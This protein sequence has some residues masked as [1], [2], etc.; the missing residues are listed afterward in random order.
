MSLPPPDYHTTRTIG[1]GQSNPADVRRLRRALTRAGYGRFGNPPAENVTPGLMT[2]IARFQS[3]FGLEPDSV[4]RP[5][6]PTERALTMALRARSD[7]GDPALAEL[8]ETFA[9]NTAAGLT[10]RPHPRDRNAGLWLDGSSGS[11]GTS[12]RQPNE[13]QVA[14]GP[15]ALLM[16]GGRA[17]L[18]YLGRA[19]GLGTGAA[20][21]QATIEASRRNNA[22]RSMSKPPPDVPPF[23]AEPPDLGEGDNIPVEPPRFPNRLEFPSEPPKPP[24][25]N[26]KQT[27]SPRPPDKLIFTSLENDEFWRQV[28][29]LK[30]WGSPQTK[31]LNDRAGKLGV[32]IGKEYG[33]KLKMTHGGF[34]TKEDGER[35]EHQSELRLPPT[36]ELSDPD[37]P[38]ANG[39]FLDVVLTDEETEVRI[40]INTADTYARTGALKPR[41]VSQEAKVMKNV[42]TKDIFIWLPKPRGEVDLEEY[43]KTFESKL[44]KAIEQLPSPPGKG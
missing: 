42:D 27:E 41:E 34:G 4:I 43:V 10:F 12:R 19:L 3:D 37:R 20:A 11:Q 21:G 9:R 13:T 36:D 32:E 8:R 22:K 30:R 14:A 40:L 38:L 2:A 5:G 39:S 33:R 23:P 16:Q 35:G 26:G 31:E 17:A 24:E 44:R 1:A 18:P 25:D 15:A 29:I 6:G 28:S 7:G